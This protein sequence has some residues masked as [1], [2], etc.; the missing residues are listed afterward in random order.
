MKG[1]LKISIA[2]FVAIILLINI[3]IPTLKAIAVEYGNGDYQLTVETD[4]RELNNGTVS[5]KVNNQNWENN[6][7]IFKTADGNNT[8]VVTVTVLS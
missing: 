5:I 4:N 8:V 1:K 2:F 7:D 6:S 3:F